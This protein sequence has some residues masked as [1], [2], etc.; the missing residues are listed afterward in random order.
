MGISVQRLAR[1]HIERN[2]SLPWHSSVMFPDSK[3]HGA[4][5]GPTWGRQDPGGPHVGPVKLY[6]W[7]LVWCMWHTKPWGIR[8]VKTQRWLLMLRLFL[9]D[10]YEENWLCLFKI[11]PSITTILSCMWWTIQAKL[12]HWNSQYGTGF[13][14]TDTINTTAK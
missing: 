3:V 11:T 12:Y 14:W 6:I 9:N 5:M 7:V 13:R 8:Q 4:N 2:L 1:K 10:L